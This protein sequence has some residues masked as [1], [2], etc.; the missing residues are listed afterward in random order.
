MSADAK[1]SLGALLEF[2]RQLEQ[3]RISYRLEHNRADAVMV[4]IAVPG[5]RWEVEFFEDGQV[6]VERFVSGG[7]IQGE[8]LLE[9]LI[10]E[11]GDPPSGHPVALRDQAK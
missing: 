8:E 4:L 9:D 11:F 5:Q 3:H 7:D 1:T 6:E 2:L 10:R